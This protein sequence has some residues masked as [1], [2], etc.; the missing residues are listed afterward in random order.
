[1]DGLNMG[2]IKEMPVELPCIDEQRELVS[3]IV[4]IE[5]RAKHVAANY[6]AQKNRLNELRQ[7]I[8]RRAFAGKLA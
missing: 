4:D 2:I 6:R 1:M 5:S 8:L 7:S 3:R